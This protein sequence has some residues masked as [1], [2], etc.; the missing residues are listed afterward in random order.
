[1]PEE[2]I[3]Y[4]VDDDDA[5]RNSICMLLESCGVV[6]RPYVSAV[7]FLADLPQEHGCLLVDVNM[8]GMNGLELL[9]QLRGR[10]IAIPVIVMTS[11]PTSWIQLAVDRAQATLLQKPFRSGELMACVDNALGRSQA[12]DPKC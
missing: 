10:G 12:R 5:V 8:P 4:V 6:A 1:M 3:I 11:A 9:D 7:A 2:R